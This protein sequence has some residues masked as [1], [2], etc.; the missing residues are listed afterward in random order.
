MNNRINEIEH[1][2]TQTKAKTTKEW[3]SNIETGSE[4]RRIGKS[5]HIRIP[6]EQTF[7]L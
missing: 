4:F 3:E 7:H 5:L 6:V 2:L 1:T